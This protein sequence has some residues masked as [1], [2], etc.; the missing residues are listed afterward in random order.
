MVALRIGRT[1]G[2]TAKDLFRRFFTKSFERLDFT[3][4]AGSL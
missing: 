3:R 4:F 1:I 2:Y